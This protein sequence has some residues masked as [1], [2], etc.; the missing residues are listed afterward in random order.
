M[1]LMMIL[2]IL[3]NESIYHKS[4]AIF[5]FFDEESKG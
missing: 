5:R 4:Q 2:F 1:K 3:S